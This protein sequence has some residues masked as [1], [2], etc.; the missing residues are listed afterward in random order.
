MLFEKGAFTEKY[1]PGGIIV[2]YNLPLAL[3]CKSNL[4][5]IFNNEIHNIF[6][7]Y[8]NRHHMRAISFGTAIEMDVTMETLRYVID[9]YGICNVDSVTAHKM[10]HISTIPALLERSETAHDVYVAIF[11]VE[12]NFNLSN[13]QQFLHALSVQFH[14]GGEHNDISFNKQFVTHSDIPLKTMAKSRV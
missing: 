9:Y 10:K 4:D 3:D 12:Q 11:L 14:L 1:I 7:S 8:D 6:A 13:I 2:V 5:I